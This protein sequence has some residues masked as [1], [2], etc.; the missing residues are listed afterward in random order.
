MEKERVVYEDRITELNLD[1]K[2]IQNQHTMKKNECQELSN[3]NKFMKE[4]LKSNDMI[5]NEKLSQLQKK[6][7]SMNNQLAW[8]LPLRQTKDQTWSIQI[9]SPIRE[10]K[11]EVNEMFTVL[12]LISSYLILSNVI[13][14]YLI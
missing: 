13:L 1:M 6:L 4:T 9:P 11:Q 8:S 10:W 2:Q 3:A 12:Y 5:W 7:D 14:S